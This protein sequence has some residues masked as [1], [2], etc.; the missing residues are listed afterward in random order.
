MSAGVI[1]SSARNGFVLGLSA[2]LVLAS[3][4]FLVKPNISVAAFEAAGES[5]QTVS[6]ASM[7][8]AMAAPAA[9]SAAGSMEAATLAL[10]TRLA[11]QGGADD[12]WELLA[13]SYDFL[14]RSDEASL[15]REHR[16]AP[17]SDLRDAV[18]AS[19]MLLS[20]PRRSTVG[21]PGAAGHPEPCRRADRQR[22]RNTVVVASSRRRAQHMPRLPD[23]AP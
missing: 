2:G 4:F 15:A 18:A 16:T 14:G 22:A 23:S 7:P 19:A 5:E 8:P 1:T 20:G 6:S 21:A 11:T 9:G 13:Q 10:K 3:A 12:Q 17:D